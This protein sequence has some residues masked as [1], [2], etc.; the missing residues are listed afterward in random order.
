MG[1]LTPT[2]GPSNPQDPT[3]LLESF[4]CPPPNHVSKMEKKLVMRIMCAQG[5]STIMFI[6]KE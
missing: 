4:Q 5:F 2:A 1:E 3:H 6:Y